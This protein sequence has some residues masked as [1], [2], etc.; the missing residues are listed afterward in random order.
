MIRQDI[1]KMCEQAI[2]KDLGALN[3][4]PHELANTVANIFYKY[5]SSSFETPQSVDTQNWIPISA[6][7]LQDIGTKFLSLFTDQQD[8]RLDFDLV[9]DLI[10]GVRMC[11]KSKQ[12]DVYKRMVDFSLFIIK[13]HI[14]DAIN[15]SYL[16]L[17]IERYLAR[18]TVQEIPN[19]IDLM[20][21]ENV[22]K[23]PKRSR[24]KKNKAV[25]C[26]VAPKKAKIRK[27]APLPSKRK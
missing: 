21:L 6:H 8:I 17:R 12:P 3:D 10:K 24:K 14:K 7:R 1:I 9:P 13:Y 27:A 26:K 23:Q 5:L 19:L 22:K 16:R 11:D 2:C 25:A 20:H 15:K 18:N 4:L